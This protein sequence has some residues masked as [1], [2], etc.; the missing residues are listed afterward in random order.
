MSLCE[1]LISDLIYICIKNFLY[2]FCKHLFSSSCIYI[3]RKARCDIKDF[4][5]DLFSK[6]LFSGLFYTV[7]ISS[8]ILISRFTIHVLFK[9]CIGCMQG[10]IQ[11]RPLIHCPIIDIYVGFFFLENLYIRVFFIEFFFK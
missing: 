1:Y 7:I 4:F 9:D 6:S 2:F 11:H 10:T 5:P 3:N 8:K